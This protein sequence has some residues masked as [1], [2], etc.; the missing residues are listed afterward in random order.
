MNATC[1]IYAAAT[2]I[3]MRENDAYEDTNLNLHITDNISYEYLP[4]RPSDQ[5]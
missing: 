4:E 2:N 1:L 5:L 3:A